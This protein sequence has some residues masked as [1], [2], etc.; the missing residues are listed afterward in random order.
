M[1][2]VHIRLLD[3]DD[4]QLLLEF[5]QCNRTWFESQIEA[6]PNDFYSS[7]GVRQHIDEMLMAYAVRRVYPCLLVDESGAILGRANL[8]NIQQAEGCAEVGYRI[9]F[10]HQGKGMATKALAHLIK[11]A[12][13]EWEL[14]QLHAYVTDDNLASSRVLQKSG[15]KADDVVLGLATVNQR[16]LNGKRYTLIL[17]T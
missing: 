9:G 1:K 8:K 14:R 12:R 6:R 10:E 11:C 17:A 7:K 2:S 13:E 5:E 4:V 16:A 3:L 15:F